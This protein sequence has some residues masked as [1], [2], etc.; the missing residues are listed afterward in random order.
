MLAVAAAVAVA[1]RVSHKAPDATGG[2][3]GWRGRVARVSRAGGGGGGLTRC[4]AA[5]RTC[6]P[7][8][9]G[10]A[11]APG[12][13]L[14]TDEV[15]R[16]FLDLADGT[17]L[18]LD[19]STEIV[20][21]AGG[22]RA[23]LVRGAIAADVAHLASGTARIDL[24]QG[25]AEVLGTKFAL[26]ADDA[27]TSV[28]VSR[29]AVRLHDGRARS[30]TVRAG[31]EGR[32]FA[33]LPPD[34]GAAPDLGGTLVW[35]EAGGQPQEE[36]S[37]RGLGELRAK[38]PGTE[39]ELDRAVRLSAHAVKVRIAGAVARTEVDEVF[40]NETGDVLEGIYRFPL[41]PDAKIERLALEV[42]GR[43]VEGAFVDRDRA[44]AIWRGAIVHAAP[45]APKPKE[46][47]VW[48]PGPWR[49]PALL[50]WQRGGRFE[51]RIYPIPRHG[52]RRIVLA[53]TQTLSPTG[54]MR[55]YSYP[56]AHDPA[57]ST[58]VDR[59]A[60]DVQVRGYDPQLGVR[61]YGYPLRRDKD[62]SDGAAVLDWSA[63]GFVPS[64]DL[65][66]MFPAADRDAELSAW[67]YRAGGADQS[68]AMSS[69][70]SYVAIALRPRLP[71]IEENA[72]RDFALV[73]DSSRSMFG[74][75]YQRA[76]RLATRFAAELDPA[77]RVAVLA[78]DSQ[79]RALQGG[80][81]APGRETT[82]RIGKF[83]SA[84]TPDGASDVA[85]AIAAA[86]A[87]GGKDGG[88]L[89]V[90]YFG[91]GAP[92]MGPI[93]PASVTRAVAQA[94]PA[95]R[96]TVTAV[97]IGPESD[98]QML[99]AV[100]RGGGGVVLPHVPGQTTAEAAFAVLGSA[101]GSALRDVTL[102]LPEELH[103]V[104]PRKLDTIAAGSEAFVVARLAGAEAAGTIVLRGKL[105]TR[106]FE[107]RYPI[108]IVPSSGAGN[109]FVPR[110][111]AA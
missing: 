27:W 84:I 78:C 99:G 106:D 87:L 16:A 7:V 13:R 93:R 57:G 47:I 63:N 4:D 24:P 50:E 108:K 46:E 89:R 22:R 35:G 71:R 25:R 105:G 23:Q 33:D 66:I 76:I 88:A 5:G 95:G 73:V 60:V 43:M 81:T 64:G 49:D 6:A 40:S 12:S 82:D 62:T 36:T 102:T 15:T 34:V 91:D 59:F 19:R 83:L 38:K 51:L 54:G 97:A 75:T 31:E 69:D 104:A 53:Y 107:Q 17:Q 86:A 74:E 61:A 9:G 109:A 70:G 28:D 44:A 26:R 18:A 92:T 58:R 111:F 56:L 52:S 110:L 41:P 45:H 100:A 10:A 20:F 55:R 48:V 85:G 14:R 42:D 65:Q 90:V 3:D 67:A 29:G 11:I 79:C 101:Y 72:R 98:L 21:G 30:I 1:W 2:G 94:I 37:A 68:P 8:D 96:G 103:E 39:R 32:I 80:L 77:D